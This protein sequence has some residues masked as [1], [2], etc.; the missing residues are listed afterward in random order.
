[1]RTASHETPRATSSHSTTPNEDSDLARGSLRPAAVSY[2]RTASG[3]S[4]PGS[5]VHHSDSR[6]TSKRR[7]S[8]RLP[9]AGPVLMRRRTARSVADS[10]Q[11]GVV[12]VH[13]ARPRM[14]RAA[15]VGVMAGLQSGN[16]GV[17]GGRASIL[18]TRLSETTRVPRTLRRP[19]LPATRGSSGEAG[20]PSR[21]NVAPKFFAAL[22]CGPARRSSGERRAAVNPER[23][24][25]VHQKVPRRQERSNLRPCWNRAVAGILT[26][27]LGGLTQQRREE[28]Q[29]TRENN[30]FHHSGPVLGRS[31]RSERDFCHLQRARRGPRAYG[32]PVNRQGGDHAGEQQDGGVNNHPPATVVHTRKPKVFVRSWK[33]SVPDRTMSGVG[34]TPIDR[35]W[36]QELRRHVSAKTSAAT[37]IHRPPSA[38]TLSSVTTICPMMHLLGNCTMEGLDIAIAG[39]IRHQGW[40][41]QDGSSRLDGGTETPCRPNS[42]QSPSV[43]AASL[44]FVNEGLE[45]EP[46]TR[47]HY[48]LGV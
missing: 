20:E 47:F 1:M 43:C 15:E 41:V 38:D 11:E 16:G 18:P 46:A 8:S 37:A 19:L 14:S 29:N 17:R 7:A 42:P 26:G 25:A 35:P 2:R 40:I 36:A 39:D 13:S 9:G 28:P 34:V 6:P 48:P 10:S 45:F 3:R 44:P 33:L 21:T 4:A 32:V 24:A 31:A 27:P 12:L 30:Y 22:T 5:A 23:A